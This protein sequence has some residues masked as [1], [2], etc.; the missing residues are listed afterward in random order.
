[1]FFNLFSLLTFHNIATKLIKMRYEYV[2]CQ[3]NKLHPEPRKKVSKNIT[4]PSE[5]LCEKCQL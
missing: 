1:M 2:I 3:E 5:D 4:T